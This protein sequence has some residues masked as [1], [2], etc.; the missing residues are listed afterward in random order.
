[1]PYLISYF[2]YLV[3][4]KVSYHKYRKRVF[5]VVEE[6]LIGMETATS[7]GTARVEAPGLSKAREKAGAVPTKSVRHNGNLRI[8]N[9]YM[10]V[11]FMYALIIHMDIYLYIRILPITL[12]YLPLIQTN[13]FI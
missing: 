10:N 4:C 5:I 12:P 7:V 6:D 1:M 3:E 13:L 11:S 9:A 2:F 8:K